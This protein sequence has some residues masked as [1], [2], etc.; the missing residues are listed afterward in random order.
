MKGYSAL[1]NIARLFHKAAEQYP[2]HVAIIHGG[3]RITYAQLARD[4]RQ[5]AMWL[6]YKGLGK[7]DRILVFVPMGIALYRTVLAIFHIGATAVF[8]D[9]WVNKERMELCCRIAQ[10]KGFVGILKA[11]IYAHFSMELRK[12][13]IRLGTVS[14]WKAGQTDELEAVGSTDAALITFTTGS[15]GTPKAAKRAHG[16]LWEQFNA[17][18]DEMEP[19]P[20][21]VDV[22]ILPIMLLVNLA[23]GA[24]S[25]VVPYRAN[26]AHKMDSPKIWKLMGK[27]RV[28]R[29]T[30]SPF[31]AMQL[32]HYGINRGADLPHLKK[33][34]TGGA[35]VFPNEVQVLVNAFPNTS[36]KIVYGS[37]EVEPISSIGADT[38]AQQRSLTDGLPVGQPFHKTEVRIMRIQDESMLCNNEQELEVLQQ[39]TGTIGEIIV[40]GPHVL[41]EYY[42]NPEALARNK[43][44]VQG[45]C[46]H[47]TGDSG[48]LAADDQLYLT[49]RCNTL[50]WHQGQLLSPFV[51]EHKFRC[52]PGVVMGTIVELDGSIVAVLETERKAS[53]QQIT[54]AI[55]AKG[56]PLVAIRWV[57]KIPRD[58]RHHS[59]I[60]Y[61]KLLL[62][63]GR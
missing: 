13:P 21:D 10:C 60:D 11:R 39:P 40:A 28:N 26:K 2:T 33:I 34:F 4:V 18:N 32:A 49:G 25:V 52:I 43:I 14:R 12:I 5:T 6:R 30:A 31:F 45:K 16:F 22:T 36:I 51:Y 15:T 44:F 29:M 62:A 47:R 37:T 63:I 1:H 59:K 57:G 35:P 56:T 20:M 58:P 38:L 46:W 23:A 42:D 54:E 17:L 8:L 27:Y 53:Q 3:D 41:S 19:Q 7:G 9:E 61:E 55:L 50:I 24:T 48:Y